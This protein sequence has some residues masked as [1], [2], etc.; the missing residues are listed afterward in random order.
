MAAPVSRVHCCWVC[1]VCPRG[2]VKPECG[3]QGWKGTPAS[4]AGAKRGLVS[5]MNN[6]V[7]ALHAGQKKHGLL[8]KRGMLADKHEMRGLAE[9]MLERVLPTR[10]GMEECEKCC[11][12]CRDKA[13]KRLLE[14]KDHLLFELNH[15]LEDG[16]KVK[17][18]GAATTAA[19]AAAEAQ[20]AESSSCGPVPRVDERRVLQS[21]ARSA[22][23]ALSP[24][25]ANGTPVVAARSQTPRDGEENQPVPR[26]GGQAHQAAAR[27]EALEACGAAGQVEGWESDGRAPR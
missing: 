11:D 9:A 19:A 17:L 12:V 25:Q 22:K 23:R 1:S 13:I 10:A 14:D 4:P 5:V 16:D 7:Q 26:L 18:P 2:E 24:C 8:F 27:A 3:G 21:P 20:A 15:V 6:I